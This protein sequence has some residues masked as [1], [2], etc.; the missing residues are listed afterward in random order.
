MFGSKSTHIVDSNLD[1]DAL[2]IKIKNYTVSTI[3]H[4]SV[5]WTVGPA[6][7]AGGGEEEYRHCIENKGIQ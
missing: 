2:Q 7:S 4:Q 5:E 3:I 1:C 6:G